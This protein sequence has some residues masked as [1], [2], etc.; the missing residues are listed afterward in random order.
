MAYIPLRN[1]GRGGLVPDQA[2]YDVE[3]TQFPSGD[4]VS[5]Q[6]GVIGKTLGHVD[7]GITIP[8]KPVSIAGYFKSGYN[9]IIIGTANKLYNYNGT[10]VRDVT[11]SSGTYSNTIRWQTVQMGSGIVFNNG[12]DTPKYINNVSLSGSGLFSDLANWPSSV[13]TKSIKPYKSFLVLAGY[14]QGSTAYRTRVR[15]SDEFS[16]EGVPASYDP[17]VTTNLAG[18]NELGGENGDLKDQLALGNTNILYAENGVYAMDFIGAPL[19]FS[20]RE[21]FSD[22]GIIN[23]GA[24]ADFDGKHLVVGTSDIYV[25]DGNTK[26]SVADLKVRNEFYKTL[27]D[28]NSVFCHSNPINSEIWICYADKYATKDASDVS[29]SPNRCLVYNWTNDAFTFKDLPNTRDMCQADILSQGALTGT[30]A[31]TSLNT[32]WNTSTAWWSNSSLEDAAAEIGIFAVNHTEKKLQRMNYTTGFNGYAFGSKIE[33]TK[34]D[35][36]TVLGT[37]NN[38]I[39]HIRGVMPQMKGS[40]VIL[41]TVGVSNTPND[42][43]NW[44]YAKAY[45]IETDNKIDVRLSGR[46]LAFKFSSYSST[47]SWNISG[48]DIDVQEVASR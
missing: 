34:I 39:K 42:P 14:N 37:S 46:Y 18:F 30:W 2:P 43:V 26:R 38:T 12:A 40:G 25:H 36:D 31:D 3:L 8:N 5:F 6:N 13:S 44:G 1:I 17:T 33:T 16:P 27:N 21:L 29:Y 19:V 28:A 22:Q 48:M 24:C 9:S 11:G 47:D 32:N 4:N 10:T 7:E 35:L 41:I 20:F 23:R 15:W 45:N